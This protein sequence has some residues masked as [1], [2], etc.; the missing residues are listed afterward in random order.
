MTT[1]AGLVCPLCRAELAGLPDRCPGCGGDLRP[2]ARVGELADCH[3]TAAVR[4]VR[5]RRWGTAAEHLAVTLAL[6]PDDVDA[7]VLLG[8]V[9]WREGQRENA[10]A[11]WADALRLD[12]NREVARVGVEHADAALTRTEARSGSGARSRGQRSH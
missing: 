7:L 8:K 4:A 2:L 5:D 11:A 3:F 1:A 6:A 9:R 10:R 12:P